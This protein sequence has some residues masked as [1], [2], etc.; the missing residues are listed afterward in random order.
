LLARTQPALPCWP[1]VRLDLDLVKAWLKGKGITD[2]PRESAHDLDVTSRVLWKA[3]YR[4]AITPEQVE[5]IVM[6]LDLPS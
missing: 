3:L 6:D 2:W 1:H 4:Q 5:R